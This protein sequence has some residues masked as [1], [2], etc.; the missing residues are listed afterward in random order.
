[1]EIAVAEKDGPETKFTDVVEAIA[2]NGEFAKNYG[3]I[4]GAFLYLR[5]IEVVGKAPSFFR[6]GWI[7]ALITTV[8]SVWLHFKS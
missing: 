5:T 7:V 3:V 4:V 6:A 1:M 2:R 8:A